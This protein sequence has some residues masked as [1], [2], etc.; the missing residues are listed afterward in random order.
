MKVSLFRWSVIA[1]LLTISVTSFSQTLTVTDG[2]ALWLRADAGVTTNENGLV[3]QWDDQSGNVNHAF[4]SAEL[5]MP[6]FVPNAITNKPALRFDG[7]ATP[8]EHDFLNIPHAESLAFT[9]DLTTLFV[10]KV[11]DFANYNAIWAKTAGNY[12]APTDLYTDINTGVMRVYRGG[13]TATGLSTVPSAQALRAGAYLVLA[14]DI[15]GSNATHYLNGQP[16]GTGTVNPDTV[17]DTAQDL[18]IGTRN[19]LFTK[20]RGDIAEILIYNRSLSATERNSAFT[21]LQNKYGLQNSPPTATI[22]A[23]PSANVNVGDIVTLNA[24]ATDLDGTIARVEFLANGALLGTAI[25]PPYSLRVRTEAAGNAVFTA[26]AVDNRDVAGVS[27]PFTLAIGS[28]G[29]ASNPVTDGVQL[30]MQAH[31]GTTL[32]AGD[33]VLEWADQSGNVNTAAQP[34]ENLAPTLVPNALNGHA[35]VRF[36][37]VNDVLDVADSDS[38]SITNDIS[39]FYVLRFDNFATFRSVW[40]KTVANQPAPTDIYGASGSGAP[41]FYRG[42]GTT[43]GNANGTRPYPA[44]AYILA[45]VQQAG[46]A[47][48]HFLN[49][50]PNGGGTITVTVADGNTPLRIGSRADGGTRLSGDF[51]ELLIYNRALSAAERT[52]LQRHLVEKY[53]LPAFVS[54][55]NASPSVAVT[56]TNVP[57]APTNFTYTVDSADSDGAITSVQLL[58]NGIMYVNDT[59]APYSVSV[60]IPYGG[61]V[62][63]TAIATDNFGART[64]TTRTYCVP[65]P[66][67]PHGLVGYWPLNGN[68]EA[69]VGPD[70]V[71]VNAPV[72]APDRLGTA[73]GALAFD[74]TKS[75]RVEIPGGGGLSG[76]QQGT[77]S[78][79]VNWTG[80]QDGGFGGSFG[81][82]LGR[83]QDGVFSANI[84]TLNAAD[85]ATAGVQWRRGSGVTITGSTPVGNDTWRHVAVT[86]TTTNSEL[87]LDGVSQGVAGASS[88]TANIT[89]P[90][91]IGAW[92]GGGGSYATASIDDVAIWNRVLT[93]I[94][95]QDLFA[96][97]SSVLNL[98]SQPDCLTIRPAT[99]SG[100]EIRWGSDGVLQH[101]DSLDGQWDDVTGATSPYPIPQGPM[102]FYRLRSL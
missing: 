78:M 58:V 102:K 12:P 92:T 71:L 55:I 62:V 47:V 33:K 88:L 39:T 36:D 13:G 97:F 83:Q 66:S 31:T 95:I 27:P 14:V 68:A 23:T 99:I 91:A 54:A 65:G 64:I 46:T 24:T 20:M 29:P 5:Q 98:Q 35:V 28:P 63:L 56:V 93:P 52:A 59:N 69:A 49:G 40:G 82:V 3:M 96:G 7:S 87:Y 44:G 73:S 30:W 89:T 21:Y 51:A 81:A 37:G 48:S 6:L 43:P 25:A 38:I 90:L 85:P 94:E 19:D 77:I 45:G 17:A 70:G 22:T 72:P 86:F 8:G 10:I 26:R 50:V 42:N 61:Q 53:A 84:I 18:K 4:Q 74:G 79:W 2:L 34:D 15:Q 101:A 41:V 80:L 32:G 57:H 11:D 100:G 1:A 67:W 60:D 16:N 9:G 76:A 75:N